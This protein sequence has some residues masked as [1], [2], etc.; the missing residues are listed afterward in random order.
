MTGQNLQYAGLAEGQRAPATVIAAV[1]FTSEDVGRTQLLRRQAVDRI[2]PVFIIREF[3]HTASLREIQRIKDAIIPQPE[4]VDTEET[5][6][7]KPL[8]SENS[9]YQTLSGIKEEEQ[10]L[11]L[12]TLESSLT[13]ILNAGVLAPEDYEQT[14]SIVGPTGYIRLQTEDRAPSTALGERLHSEDIVTTTDA[15]RRLKKEVSQTTN[16]HLPTEA[17]EQLSS[18]LIGPNLVYDP[19]RTE[20]LKEAAITAVPRVEMQ[21]RAGTTLMES[22]ERITPQILELIQAHEARQESLVPGSVRLQR[23]IGHAGLL[24]LLLLACAGL[25]HLASPDTLHQAR[26]AWLFSAAALLTLVPVKGFLYLSA[27]SRILEPALME[28]MLPLALTP[29]LVMI[30]CGGP[31]A[32]VAG[33]WTSLAA[34]VL[35]SYSS[36]I[37]LSGFVGTVIALLS[38]QEVRRRSQVFKSGLAIGMAV[39]A[40]A[41]FQ[42]LLKQYEPAFILPLALAALFGGLLSAVLVLLVLP[43]FEIL[44]ERTTDIRL[45]ELS[46]MG[47]PLL[48]R[49][50]IEAPGTYHHSLMVAN[51]AQAAAQEIGCNALLVRVCAY[52]HDT[53][54]LTK[55]ECFIENAQ[56]QQNPHDELSPSMS[57]LVIIAHVKE[58]MS[59]AMQYKL[60]R[61]I[62]EGIQQHHGTST[63]SYFFHRAKEQ[64]S[65][66]L[67]QTQNGD[68][69]LNDQDFRYPGPKPQRAEMAILFLAD[70]VE[71]ASRSMDKPTPSRIENL[72]TEII[73]GKVKDGQLDECGLTFKQ[74][75]EIKRSLTY[76]LTNMLHGRI[77]YPE[78][79][80]TNSESPDPSENSDSDSEPPLKLVYD[81]GT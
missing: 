24:L 2:A 58:G 76:N 54:K 53:G 15:A 27:T 65:K 57:T 10:P 59:L 12:E 81:A 55:P 8:Q 4:T 43:V 47:H 31:T 70:S 11:L 60:P 14:Q 1:D 78:D 13:R 18:L 26:R 33:L 6:T 9:L 25:L 5:I 40:L 64:S 62:I 71:A 46:D 77:K 35:S 21:V 16:I 42:A 39:I 48:Q 69:A 56:F 66:K 22:G 79:E 75:G 3:V 20:N 50:A 28:F 17:W 45:L 19:K 36:S 38:L 61:I 80:N 63:V 41:V 29:M 32:L 72:V 73:E 74:L 44:F 51:L 7:T 30:L 52:F 49:M 68:P 23:S 37:L 34:F 67:G